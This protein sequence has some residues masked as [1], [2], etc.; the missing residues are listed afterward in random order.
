MTCE[1]CWGQE[2]TG[3]PNCDLKTSVTPVIEGEGLMR[4]AVK[5]SIN[6]KGFALLIWGKD[7][8]GE[9]TG[10]GYS[11]QLLEPVIDFLLSLIAKHYAEKGV[12]K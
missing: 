7:K 5:I 1:K 12:G 10:V 4:D 11:I 2:Y 6:M 3:C 9:S 8:I